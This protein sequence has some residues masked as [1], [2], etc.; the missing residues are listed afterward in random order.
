MNRTWYVLNRAHT[1]YTLRIASVNMSTFVHAMSQR[2]HAMSLLRDAMFTIFRHTMLIQAHTM[3]LF[4]HT[5]RHALLRPRLPCFHAR[6]KPCTEAGKRARRKRSGA[7]HMRTSPMIAPRW[8][9]RLDLKRREKGQRQQ[10]EG[11]QK[12]GAGTASRC[13]SFTNKHR[14]C[15]EMMQRLIWAPKCVRRG[16]ARGRRDQR[17]LQL[18]EI[19]TCPQRPSSPVLMPHNHFLD[20]DYV[21]SMQRAKKRCEHGVA[22]ALGHAVLSARRAATKCRREIGLRSTRG[23]NTDKE[24]HQGARRG[25]GVSA[26]ASRTPSSRV[27]RFGAN[28]RHLSDDRAERRFLYFNLSAWPGHISTGGFRFANLEL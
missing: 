5:M 22:L 2:V 1:R 23:A 6:H 15:S 10:R 18:P 4:T 13:S 17:S 11:T 21:C 25:T 16:P 19:P 12:T 8:R 7:R 27:V 9:C 3:L 14:T 28:N 26:A 24:T 20:S